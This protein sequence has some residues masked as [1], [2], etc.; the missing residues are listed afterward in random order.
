MRR[1]AYADLSTFA[2]FRKYE[3]HDQY[4]TDMDALYP[5]DEASMQWYDWYTGGEG[6]Y[7]SSEDTTHQ[8]VGLHIERDAKL[9][10]LRFGFIRYPMI[11]A[12]ERFTMA[13]ID[14]YPHLGDWHA[15]AKLYR[16]FMEEK[17][18]FV[19][20]VN[21][22]WSRDMTGWLRLIFKQHH[23][24]LN[25]S[26]ADIP[27]MYDELEACGLKTL[28]LLGWE[29]GGFARLWP[30]FRVDERMGGEKLLREGIEYVHQKGGKVLMFLS[31]ALIDHHSDFYQK[32]G[33]DKATIRSI[34]GEDIPFA[35]TYCG[36]GTYRKIGNP[37]MPMYLACPGSPL[38]QEKMK[39]AAK[40]CLEL[41]ADGVLYDI[42]SWHPY[43]C[44]AEGHTH[45]K[46]SHSHESKA[47]NY[48]GLREYIKTFGQD[49]IILMEHNTDIFGQS[50]DI[51]HSANTQPPVR[52]RSPETAQHATDVRD[53]L[54]M[55]ELYR[56]TF[57]ELV[58]TNREC[59]EDEESYKAM[60]GFSF[61]YGLRFDMTIYRCCGSLRDIP[62]YAAYL[63]EISA[64]Y[65]QYGDFLLRG[66]FVDGDGFTL[67][68]E[69]V[70]VKGWEGCNGGLAVSLW[71]PTGEDQVVNLRS[72][73]TGRAVTI[74][75]P[76]ERVA[77]A[78][79][80][81]A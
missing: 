75:V 36:E 65:E 16:A 46:P 12:G 56:Y 68:S 40:T 62:R 9:N 67:D 76:A 20:P 43:F 60:A 19:P 64:L 3:R 57:P 71:N 30:D 72:C 17:G 25:W 2:G 41:G 34:W 73:K 1:P 28:Y 77:A 59:G 79:I 52:L 21:P 31:Y 51:S 66:R 61:L 58:A 10:V 70:L 63:K 39:E 22:E 74:I 4:H 7:C 53:D 45:A 42:G 35:E 37:A 27:T 32:E 78:V 29:A 80:D 8:T 14:C 50:M 13:P 47:A 26:Y 5:S 11:D 18:G 44:Y 23:C 54:F 48:A 15:G 81:E 6:L 55:P 24:E 38:W 69:N 33:G 49:K